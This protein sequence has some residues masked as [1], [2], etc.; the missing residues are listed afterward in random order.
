[1][2]DV[3]GDVGNKSFLAMTDRGKRFP[4]TLTSIT[5][6][7]SH[8][9]F[10][11][12]GPSVRNSV[13]TLTAGLDIRADGGYV[14]VPPS[15]HSTGRRYSWNTPIE[16]IAPMP[17]WFRSLVVG[18]KNGSVEKALGETLPNDPMQSGDNVPEFEPGTRNSELTSIAGMLRRIASDDRVPLLDNNSLGIEVELCP[19]QEIQVD[20][21]TV[22]RDLADK[23]H[24][25]V[26]PRLC[27][28]DELLD[29]VLPLKSETLR[30]E[31]PKTRTEEPR[32]DAD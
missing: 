31:A 11:Y 5:G 29:S 6:K 4:P 22:G 13:G 28:G 7:G 19:K 3:D 24:S 1:V 32:F 27:H 23:I 18:N 10:Q 2:L 14:V 8:V 15:L 26:V 12:P 30:S 16:P 25:A 21:F 20:G 17:A 9:F